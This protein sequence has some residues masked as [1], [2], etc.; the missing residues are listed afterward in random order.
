MFIKIY[1]VGCKICS[2]GHVKRN[3]ENVL[4][5][6]GMYLGFEITGSL[7]NCFR[8]YVIIFRVITP[9]KCNAL[10]FVLF[11]SCKIIELEFVYLYL[12]F[13]VFYDHYWDCYEHITGHYRSF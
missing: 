1:F 12:L 3:A 8:N 10:Q 9:L 6:S 4:I 7:K 11:L 13:K 2:P 5:L